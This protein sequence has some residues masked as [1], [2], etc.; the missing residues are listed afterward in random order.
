MY[1]LCMR[2]TSLASSQRLSMFVCGL[3]CEQNNVMVAYCFIHSHFISMLRT[4]LSCD[5][6]FFKSKK[7]PNRKSKNTPGLVQLAREFIAMH[8]AI[9]SVNTK[10]LTC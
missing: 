8:G 2:M 5:L 9:I 4:N 10:F 3:E 7:S 6:Y 1:L